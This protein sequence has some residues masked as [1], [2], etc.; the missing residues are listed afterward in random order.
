MRGAHEQTGRWHDERRIIP[1]DAGSTRV[2]VDHALFEWDHPRGCGEHHSSSSSFP[3]IRG[4]SPRMRGA[5]TSCPRLYF[6]LGIIPADAGSTVPAA[7]PEA[8]AWDHPRGCGEHFDMDG[9][10]VEA[11]GSSPRMRGARLADWLAHHPEGIIPADAGSTT[12][13]RPRQPSAGDHPR[14]C[15]EHHSNPN[16]SNKGAGSS[17]RM[18]GAR[19]VG[20]WQ[21]IGYGIIPAD[22]GSTP[23]A[24]QVIEQTEDHPRGCGEHAV[25]VPSRA[26]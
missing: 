6:G 14:G 10:P 7:G 21:L 5:P 9:V 3:V 8:W 20:W 16:Q 22:A 4:S 24:V 25:C 17:P 2:V 13:Q 15:G 26:P 23:K 1:A 12:G 11:Q 18:R 19:V